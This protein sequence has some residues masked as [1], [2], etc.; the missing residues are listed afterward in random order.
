MEE[1][2]ETLA[3]TWLASAG[4][5]QAVETSEP[6]WAEAERVYTAGLERD[7]GYAPHWLGRAALRMARGSARRYAG[8]DG[9]L[10]SKGAEADLREAIRLQPS[11]DAYLRLSQ[12]HLIRAWD[13]IRRG[14]DPRPE[15]QAGERALDEAHARGDRGAVWGQRAYFMRGRAEYLLDR[16]QDPLEACAAGERGAALAL[17]E[18]PRNAFVWFTR[19]CLAGARAVHL[20][21]TGGDP[22]PDFERAER[23]FNE[24]LRLD[25]RIRGAWERRGWMRLHQARHR[26]G[27]GLDPGPLLAAAEEDA[28]QSIEV[29]AWFTT[30]RLTRAMVRRAQ[31]RFD[32]ALADLDH[33]LRINPQDAEVWAER[34]K[35]FADRGDAAEADRCLREARRLDPTIR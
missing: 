12:L 1:A 35:L 26:Q 15:W 34:S 5:A 11:A 23:H 28:T 3:Q 27:K 7:R 19:A 31:R 13:L 9:V 29:S 10:D 6:A 25:K 32:A 17:E 30:A 24:S 4:F 16:D 18:N 8:R 20:S 14:G 33:L 2:W 22:E 21:R